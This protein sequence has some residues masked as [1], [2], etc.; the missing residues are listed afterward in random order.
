MRQPQS[1]AVKDPTTLVAA[2]ERDHPEIVEAMRLL[3]L[4][5]AEYER[6]MDAINGV[7]TTY[8]ASHTN[9]GDV[10]TA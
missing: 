8:K 4:S 10:F 3:G 9:T 5:V 2:F 6:A 7:G 1:D